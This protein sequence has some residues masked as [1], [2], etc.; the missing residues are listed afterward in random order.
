MSPSILLK[1]KQLYL[2]CAVFVFLNI[3]SKNALALPPQSDV[4]AQINT[5]V[6]LNKNGN[7]DDAIKLLSN[8]SAQERLSATQSQMVYWGLAYAYTAKR[9]DDQI[10][11]YVSKM[12]EFEPP[13]ILPEPE[14]PQKPV[15]Q[16]WPLLMKNAY[17]EVRKEK[18]GGF[19]VDIWDDRPDP[20]VK[21][22]ALLDFDTNVSPQ[23]LEKFGHLGKG[24]SDMLIVELIN[25]SSLK[26]VERQRIKWLMEEVEMQSDPGLFDQSTAVRVG[27]LLGAHTVIFGSITRL[28]GND[29]NIIARIVKVETSEILVANQITANPKALH[30][31]PKE[32]ATQLIKDLE[33]K[34][35]KEDKKNLKDVSET[36]STD[37]VISYSK[38]L[39]YMDNMEYDKAYEK[40]QEALEYDPNYTKAKEKMDSIRFLI[41]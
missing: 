34:L 2:L 10:K 22:I 20:G 31:V 13:R 11:S 36:N 1:S 8:L 6:E 26:V 38:G 12:L 16:I 25:V 32:L 33:I 5:A 15:D 24:L 3:N 40:F 4:D 39:D 35:T 29:F 14:P 9:Q 19:Q 30:R 37:A 17:Y 41:S 18:T 23:D 28:L 21:T 27:K 7:F